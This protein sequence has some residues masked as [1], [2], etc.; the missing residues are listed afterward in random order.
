VTDEIRIQQL[1]KE[2][3]LRKRMVDRKRI[4]SLLQSSM[5]TANYVGKIPLTE[6]SSTVVFRELYECIRQ[7]GDAMWWAQ[8]YEVTG[9]HEVSM[10]ILMD[11]DIEDRVKLQKL[12]W[13]RRTRNSANYRGYR[14][15][16]EEAKEMLDFWK[17]C[18]KGLID[19]AR[20]R[21]N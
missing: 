21:S 15:G 7:I 11:A 5:E 14:I 9:S 8:G 2:G 17:S 3:K 13:F 12:D 10:E 16:V 20:K 18:G 1:L 19:D 6:E 4:S